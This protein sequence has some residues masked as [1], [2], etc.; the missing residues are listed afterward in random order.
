[1]P[2]S[3]NQPLDEFNVIRRLGA[4]GFGAVYQAQDTLLNRPVAIEG[5]RT[6]N[7]PA[8]LQIWTA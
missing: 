5:V 2:V 1:M 6:C 3:P 8:R 4:G 7:P